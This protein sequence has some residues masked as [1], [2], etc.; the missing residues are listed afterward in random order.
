MPESFRPWAGAQHFTEE[1]HTSVP[2][3]KFSLQQASAGDC[4]E[5]VSAFC[6]ATPRSMR[7]S[8]PELKGRKSK[9][10]IFEHGL[11]LGD[12]NEFTVSVWS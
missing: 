12:A 10:V 7:M 1:A 8:L 2:K 5:T 9:C 4:M 6:T 3:F 11:V